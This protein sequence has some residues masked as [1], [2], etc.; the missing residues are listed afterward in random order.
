[1]N[2]NKMGLFLKKLRESKNYT[3]EQLAELIPISRQAISKWERGLA[4]PDS[5]VLVK[6]SSLFNV[7]INE[8]LLG[9]YITKNNINDI[10]Q[11]SLKLYDEKNKKSKIIKILTIIIIL[12]AIIF[13]AYYFIKSYKAVK[14]YTLTGFSDNIE[15]CEGIMVKT[16]D[17]IYFHIGDIVTKNN[18]SI[19]SIVLYSKEN[20][21]NIILNTTKDYIMITDE[22]GYNEYFNFDNINNILNN[23]YMDIYY[24]DKKETIKIN[25]NEDY[26]NNRLLFVKTI[27]NIDN[28]KFTENENND[29]YVLKLIDE[30]LIEKIKLKYSKINND[31]YNYSKENIE[32]NYSDSLKNL[33]ITISENKSFIEYFVY[34]LNQDFISYKNYKDNVSF[35]YFFNKSKCENNCKNYQAIIQKFNNIILNSIKWNY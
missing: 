31:N 2:Q 20:G 17:K 21:S 33:Q 14:I 8:I 22:N 5:S 10:N 32:I 35:N 1:M 19:N 30:N 25:V 16:N 3:Q 4:I 15:N 24:K 7:S 27:K 28:A 18:L 34:Q 6:L 23:L 26:V 29:T 11:I 9:E 13:L 12:F